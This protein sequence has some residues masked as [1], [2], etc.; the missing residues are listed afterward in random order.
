VR[1]L[2]DL[3]DELLHGGTTFKS[4]ATL[5]SPPSISPSRMASAT[6]TAAAMLNLHAVLLHLGNT[7][8]PTQ[9]GSGGGVLKSS[10]IHKELG[11]E[12]EEVG[13]LGLPE[14]LLGA[15]RLP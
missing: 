1:L 5:E 10:P 3:N 14:R 12:R 15:R 4:A 11:R 2:N 7:F 8:T 6:R 9:P 13:L